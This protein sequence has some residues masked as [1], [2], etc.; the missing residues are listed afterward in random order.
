MSSRSR[1]PEAASP[2]QPSYRSSMCTTWACR[3]GASRAAR[4]VLPDPAG[5]STAITVVSPQRGPAAR[6]A[7][8]MATTAGELSTADLPGGELGAG[9]AGLLLGGRQPLRDTHRRS[10]AG[11]ITGGQGTADGQYLVHA[12]RQRR[13]D[14][15]QVARGQIPQFDTAFFAY[16]HARAREFV[17]AA[18]RYA[19]A[20]EPFGDVGGQ[21]ET[22][23]GEL[24]H[25]VG[26]ELQRGDHAG[27][28]GDR[29]STRL[30]SS[31]VAISYAVFCLKKKKQITD[32][33]TRT[34]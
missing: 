1:S 15:G 32:G 22:L 13:V 10:P 11:G 6:A 34:R 23:R 3:G 27:H 9:V 4:V 28:G 8:V 26:V 21:R 5:P 24:G 31:H 20:H 29:K 25:P 17:R 14:G 33:D 18:E 12:G 2:C 19:L 30:N 16:A 7:A